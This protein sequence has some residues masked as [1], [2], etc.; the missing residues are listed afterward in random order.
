MKAK[1]SL[2]QATETDLAILLFKT[3]GV[4]RTAFRKDAAPD[5]ASLLQMR[6]LWYL[7]EN[8]GSTMKS[9]AEFLCIT[10]PSA[11]SIVEGLVDTRL[12]SR[13]ADD[14]DRRKIRLV[15][16]KEGKK[17]LEFSKKTILAQIKKVLSNLT[18]EEEA[19]LAHILTKLSHIYA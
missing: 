5:S 15:V 4:M 6:T 8:E 11:T 14:H 1:K 10:P 9:L 13:E 19:Q 2:I 17:R 7:S 3:V 18:A 16:S 12:L